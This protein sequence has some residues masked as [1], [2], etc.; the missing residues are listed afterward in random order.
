MA[1]WGKGIAN[2]FSFCALTGTKEVM[3]MGGI[4][5]K[6]AQKLFLTSTTHGGETHVIAAGLATIEI[7]QKENVVAYNHAMGNEFLKLN[8]EAIIKY[9]LQEYIQIADCNWMPIFIFKNK[10]KEVCSG[11][12]TLMLQEMIARG[13][14]FQGAF[15]P[16]YSHTLD[17]IRYFAAAFDESLQVF[18]QALETG[19]ESF[20]T[21]N[22]AKPVFRKYL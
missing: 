2:G 13:V 10:Q 7:F 12:R 20:L 14:L 21:G 11:M 3:E 4:R 17:D 1:T 22:P 19:Y 8:Q 15:V 18:S 5:N 6:G 9:G 16:C